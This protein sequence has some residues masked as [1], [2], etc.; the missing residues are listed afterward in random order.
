MRL[1]YPVTRKPFGNVRMNPIA[2]AVTGGNGGT[3]L[4]PPNET[5]GNGIRY[6][7]HLL[8][9]RP[10]QGPAESDPSGSTRFAQRPGKRPIAADRR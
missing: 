6:Q 5:S 1:D 7:N 2:D 10:D 8:N 4:A 9:S 3:S